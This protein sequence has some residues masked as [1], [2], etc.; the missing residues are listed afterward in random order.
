LPGVKEEMSKI[1]AERLHKSVAESIVKSEKGDLTS[2]I[3]IGIACAE[4]RDIRIEEILDRADR[5]LYTAKA[6]DRNRA[7]FDSAA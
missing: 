1:I 3:S 7:I 5:S 2:T 4:G 6:Q